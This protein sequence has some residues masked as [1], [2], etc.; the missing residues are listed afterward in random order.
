MVFFKDMCLGVS[1]GS[2]VGGFVKGVLPSV[3][4]GDVVLKGDCKTDS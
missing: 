1:S 4:R 2:R 3:F